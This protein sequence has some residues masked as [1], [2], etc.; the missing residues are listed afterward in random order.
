MADPILPLVERP[1]PLLDR[2]R[3]GNK[4]KNPFENIG[5]EL[6]MLSRLSE[7]EKQVAV[8][9]IADGLRTGIADELEIEEEKV[10]DNLINN[11]IDS[12]DNNTLVNEEV[13]FEVDEEI[14]E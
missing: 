10:N 2:I 7:E 11:I 12:L 13:G 5:H 3:N 6:V 9:S 8:E 14:E 4:R 1:A